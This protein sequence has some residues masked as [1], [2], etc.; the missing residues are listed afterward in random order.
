LAEISAVIVS[1]NARDMLRAALT[2]LRNSIEQSEV[3]VIVVDNGSIDSRPIMIKSW[4][5][6]LSDAFT[7]I[8]REAREAVGFYDERSYLYY[9]EDDLCHRLLAAGW[10]NCH[11]ADTRVIHILGESTKRLDPGVVR[12]V[13]TNDPVKYYSKYYDLVA[14]LLIRVFAGV[15][16]MLHTILEC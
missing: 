7:M 8:R 15:G 6:V 16:D 10:K 12:A 14:G 9:T 4:F 1:H 5:R 11:V 3:K 2:A 13:K